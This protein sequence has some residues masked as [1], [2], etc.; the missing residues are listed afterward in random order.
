MIKVNIVI[1]FLFLTSLVNAQESPLHAEKGA[2]LYENALSNSD[3]MQS[4]TMEGPGTAEFKDGWMHMYAPDE[5]G[6]HVF[7]CPVDFPDRFV[8]EW[9]AQ[10]MET[11]AG[12]CIVF[13]AAMG[14]N[15]EDIF[16][17][18]LKPRDGVFKKYTKGDLNSYHISYYANGKDQPGREITHLR[19]N[20]GFHKVQ[21]GKP[22]IPVHSA[23]IHQL[24]LIKDGNH[25]VMSVDGREIINWADDGK[26]YGKALEGGKIGMRQMKWT[27]F[28][29]RNFK[30]WS[31]GADE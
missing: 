16:D 17:P 7:W 14:L 25:I 18:S 6:H 5:K 1:Y 23:E 20:K 15:G 3:Q 10:N 31:L 24:K 8:L 12:L 11:D 19:K 9:E 27:H 21:V 2:L 4:W 29:Y 26:K 30:V 13:F 22:G 28:R